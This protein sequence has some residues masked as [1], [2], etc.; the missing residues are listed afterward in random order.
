MSGVAAAT[1][2]T[3]ITD[4]DLDAL[5]VQMRT[6]ATEPETANFSAQ[7]GLVL[8]MEIRRLSGALDDLRWFCPHCQREVEPFHESDGP[9]EVGGEG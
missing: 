4:A 8:V 3:Q 7:L 1:P 5:E 9:A 6:Q 2:T